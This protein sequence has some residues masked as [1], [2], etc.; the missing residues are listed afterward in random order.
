M[1]VVIHERSEAFVSTRCGLEP[2]ELGVVCLLAA[3]GRLAEMTYDEGLKGAEAE[4][5]SRGRGIRR[6][7]VRS[8]A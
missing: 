2:L 4:R 1:L 8:P 6:P 3:S 5:K 7:V